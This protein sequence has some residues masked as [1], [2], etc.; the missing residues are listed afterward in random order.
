MKRV[1]IT[2]GGG[3]IGSSL[4]DRLAAR[5]VE[6]VVLDDFRT[7]RRE[8]LAEA[9]DG[10]RV[11]LIDG[12]VL[13]QAAVE[14]ATRGCDWVFHLQANADVRRGLENPRRDLEQNTIATSNVLEAM[15]VNDVKQIA[16]S[17]TGSVYGEP[18]VFP[19]P[20]DAP[21]P[22]QTSLYAASKLAGEGMIEA[23]ATGFAFTGLIFRF[24]SILGERYTHGHV[25]DFFCALKRDPSRLRV[26]GDG[27]QEK[28]YLYVQDCIDAILLAVEHH[29]G[30]PG[31]H[32]Y[33]LGADET[34]V[35]DDSVAIITD[36]LGLSP[37]IEHTGGRRGWTG[38]SPLIHLDTKRIR[39]LGWAPQ[40]TIRESVERTVQWLSASEYAWREQVSDRAIR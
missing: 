6:V 17:S 25:F 20:E 39:A 11:R 28:S 34:I 13:D 4:V 5:D 16:F 31:A 35:V 14:E 7:G 38:D 21:F 15:R 36:Q 12:D 30:R 26:L 3:F 8:F 40:L 18:D 19:T 29:Q 37:E 10:S 23:Y 2:G 24:V 27:R 9:L 32:V 22:M 33:N 1:C